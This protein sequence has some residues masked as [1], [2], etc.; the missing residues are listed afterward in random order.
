V[1]RATGGYPTPAYCRVV[2]G[3]RRFLHAEAS[4]VSTRRE[5]VHNTVILVPVPV[6]RQIAEAANVRKNSVGSRGPPRYVSAAFAH[7]IS[8]AP[9]LRALDGV[10]KPAPPNTFPV[11]PRRRIV[12]HPP[13]LLDKVTARVAFDI[14]D[15]IWRCLNESRSAKQ[16]SVFAV[17]LKCR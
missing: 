6:D 7:S 2:C 13:Q 1:P 9:R 11:C 17:R 15:R 12:A 3:S 14:I 4:S 8:S 10:A 5:P 16:A